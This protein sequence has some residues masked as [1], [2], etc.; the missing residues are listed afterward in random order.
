[1]RESWGKVARQKGGNQLFGYPYKQNFHL[2]K[3][4]WGF[5]H[6]AL[7]HVYCAYKAGAQVTLSNV[8]NVAS[9]CHVVVEGS[10]ALAVLVP[11]S[12]CNADYTGR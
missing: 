3:S 6:S 11:T 8:L 12:Y 10:S 1:M 9:Y 7:T 4:K 2:L 5:E